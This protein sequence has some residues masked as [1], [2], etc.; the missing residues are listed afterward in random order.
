M[1][2]RQHG[3]GGRAGCGCNCTNG[4]SLSAL[5]MRAGRCAR[6]PA[7]LG[8]AGGE[9]ARAAPSRQLNGETRLLQS[10]L[11]KHKNSPRRFPIL[12]GS[13]SRSLPANRLASLPA[14]LPARPSVRA[15]P[16]AHSHFPARSARRRRR[17]ARASERAP[18]NGV[19]ALAAAASSS[20]SHSRW[21]PFKVEGRNC[22]AIA[23]RVALGRP[24]PGTSGGQIHLVSCRPLA[25]QQVYARA[26][27]NGL[28]EAEEPARL[29]TCQPACLPAWLAARARQA[30]GGQV[31]NNGTCALAHRD[32]RKHCSRRLN[33]HK[34]ICSRQSREHPAGRAG[35]QPAGRSASQRGATKASPPP[36]PL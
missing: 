25:E 26:R 3:W 35:K 31:R 33:R 23:A 24:A 5:P 17:L 28:A 13:H 4:S 22:I 9:L 2:G 36:P 11:Y 30:L 12:F 8:W 7:A 6:W 19:S 10:L 1:D 32:G 18:N 27:N 14:C 15:P 20:S 21:A 16:R 34:L 29:P